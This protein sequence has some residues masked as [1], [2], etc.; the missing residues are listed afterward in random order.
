[1]KDIVVSEKELHEICKRLGHELTERYKDNVLPPVFIGVMKGALPFMMDL[2]RE[3]ECPILTDYV[4][5]SS[6][7]GKESTGVIKL[8][9]DIDTDLTGRD[10]VIVEDIIDTGVTLEWF[11]EY[12][13]NNY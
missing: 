7:M 1:M 8:K 4:T 13:K 9:K 10:V 12:L 6:Y 11:K 3:V 2:I 5:I